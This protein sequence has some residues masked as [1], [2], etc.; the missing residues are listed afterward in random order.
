MIEVKRQKD[1][2]LI[3]RDVL[4]IGP[5]RPEDFR[6]L[7]ETIRS[8]ELHLA[9]IVYLWS[10]DIESSAAA[11][12]DA[13]KA[14][15]DRACMGVLQLVQAI[16]AT[17]GLQVDSLWLVTR[18]A[19]SFGNQSPELALMQSPV[20]GLGRV[21]RNEYPGLHCRLVDLASGRQEEIAFLVDELNAGDDTEDEIGLDG[22]LRYV[23]R[24]V[25]TSPDSTRATDGESTENAAPFR[26]ELQRPGFLDS[27]SAR[28]LRRA[29]P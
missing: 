20:W 7:L 11:T 23:H 25:P 24:F 19:Q 10:F 8:Q 14:T 3:D 17:S 9:G 1:A 6:D 22:E 21:I 28:H 12:T 2:I 15:A 27:F 13:L 5:D 16:A 29:P 18:S 26:I 4:S